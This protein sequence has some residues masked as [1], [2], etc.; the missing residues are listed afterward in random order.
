MKSL[1]LEFMSQ[2]DFA[3][4]KTGTVFT[5]LWYLLAQNQIVPYRNNSSRVIFDK[6]ERSI[7]FYEKV[8]E[9]MYS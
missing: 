4:L 6:Q 3:L 2:S 9:Q 1:L 8:I 7:D 5:V